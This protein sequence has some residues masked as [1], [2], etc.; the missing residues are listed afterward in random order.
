MTKCFVTGWTVVEN[1]DYSA[2]IDDNLCIEDFVATCVVASVGVCEAVVGN[3][4]EAGDCGE[5]TVMAAVV[6]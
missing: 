3:A 4:C 2:A 5:V 1:L 6:V